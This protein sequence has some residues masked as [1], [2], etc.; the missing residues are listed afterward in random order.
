MRVGGGVRS[1]DAL[2]VAVTV[3]APEE[4][5]LTV[6]NRPTLYWY[7]SDPVRDS[8][9]IA[10]TDTTS[11]AVA[12]TPVLDVN[13]PGPIEAGVHAFDLADHDVTLK[14]GV[15]YQWFVAVVKD[16]T[17]RSKDIIAGGSIVYTP[18]DSALREELAQ[19]DGTVPAITY[20]EFG[21][22]YDAV[23]DLSSRIEADPDDPQMRALRADLLEQVGLESV[24][25]YDRGGA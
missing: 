4:A 8:V 22:W 13:I 12:A 24:A 23:D 7:L 1:A 11:L 18:E 21:V 2:D 20:A 15:E 6:S 19:S 14:D 5:G 16:P 9:E 10:L 17:Q 25:S 3:L